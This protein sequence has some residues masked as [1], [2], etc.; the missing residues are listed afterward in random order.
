MQ[1]RLAEAARVTEW[2]RNPTN[3]EPCGGFPTNPATA[4]FAGMYAWYGDET[5]LT[6]I[7]ERMNGVP[8]NPTYAG[9]AGATSSIAT[10]ESTATLASRIRSNHIRGNTRGSTFRLTL[11]ALLKEE[12]ELT[13]V[14]PK[15]LE[16][17]SNQRLT[18]WMIEHLAVA[19]APVE[20]RS[21]LGWIE[22]EVVDAFDPPLNLNHVAE[23]RAVSSFANFVARSATDRYARRARR[24]CEVKASCRGAC[25]RAVH[26][27]DV[28]RQVRV[29]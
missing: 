19:V 11:A 3:A 6:L 1:D 14:R 24:L 10:K 23:H 18:T 15:T 29:R 16:P 5:V 27:C 22:V 12:L 2:L 17:V 9:Q 26:L 4:A 21:I 28:P 13:C 8:K 20:D 7:R 25:V